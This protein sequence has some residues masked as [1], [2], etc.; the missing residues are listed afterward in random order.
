[1]ALASAGGGRILCLRRPSALGPQYWSCPEKNVSI[2]W[3][4][5]TGI[6]DRYRLSG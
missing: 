4:L 1:L 5:L 2:P 6:G 3:L